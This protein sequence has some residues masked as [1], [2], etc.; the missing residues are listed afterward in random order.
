[1]ERTIIMEPLAVA[2]I[3]RRNSV[4]FFL[5][6]LA[7]LAGCSSETPPAAKSEPAKPA[8]EA[9]K[10]E[11]AEKPAEKAAAAPIPLPAKPS[12]AAKEP[13][14]AAAVPH[15]EQGLVTMAK[16]SQAQPEPSHPSPA[17]PTKS[18]KPAA[19]TEEAG[20]KP[21]APRDLGSPLVDNVKGLTRLDPVLPI[22]LDGQRKQVVF[23]AETCRADYPLEF[24]VTF[25]D[26]GYESCLVT[27][28]KP[29]LVHAGLLAAGAKPGK[30]VQFDPVY[31][32]P[33]GTPI[34]IEVRWK[35]KDGKLHTAP[36]QQWIRNVKTRKAMDV[37][38]VFAG[39]GFGKDPQTQRSVYWGDG[40]DFIAVLNL[41]TATLDIPVESSSALESRTYEG[42]VDNIPPKG[43]PV[44]VVLKPVL[45]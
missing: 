25:R 13:A 14:A 44:T 42:F 4:V 1:M 39:S 28:V 31:A 11:P 8:A 45:K 21:A 26:R 15:G 18:A 17:A 22:W 27:D 3:R 36:A 38:W 29:S 16:P 23:L 2:R 33:T 24:F 32:P 37:N 20:E 9:Q 12:P 40:G 7:V 10:S 5:G 6:L 41:P 30:P 34:Q 35:D 19:A 43:T